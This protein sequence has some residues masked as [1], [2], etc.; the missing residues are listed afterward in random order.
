MTVAEVKGP[1]SLA[2]R[3]SG[4]C[5]LSLFTAKANQCCRK[6][7]KRTILAR[8][9]LHSTSKDSDA[10]GERPRR[11]RLQKTATSRDHRANFAF[12]ALLCSV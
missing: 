1:A 4:L 7:V 11:R 10:R 8:S 9:E 5:F 6:S 2:A 3:K 12:I